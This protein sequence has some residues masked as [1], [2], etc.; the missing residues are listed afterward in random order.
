MV[1]NMSSESHFPIGF[2]FDKSVSPIH[3]YYI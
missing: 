1:T 3:V 2:V